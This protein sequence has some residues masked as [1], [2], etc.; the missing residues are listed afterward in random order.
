MRHGAA[1]GLLVVICGT[2]PVMA[3][4][5]TRKLCINDSLNDGTIFKYLEWASALGLGVLVLN[6]NHKD[7]RLDAE[8]HCIEAWD[9]LVEPSPYRHVAIVAHSYGGCCTAALLAARPAA[10]L[11]RLRA[12]AFTDSVHG[13]SAEARKDPWTPARRSEPAGPVFSVGFKACALSVE[14]PAAA[15]ALSLAEAASRCS[16]LHGGAC[17]QLGRIR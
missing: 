7:N 16:S 15:D 8:G 4:Q 6:P 14:P 13:R 10:V 12:I 2:G 17:D 1:D 5:W 9:Q 3:G 11:A